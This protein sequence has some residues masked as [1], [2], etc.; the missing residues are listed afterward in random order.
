MFSNK[1]T[2]WDKIVT[3]HRMLT[4]TA[5]QDGKTR[6]YTQWV[7]M[8]TVTSLRMIKTQSWTGWVVFVMYFKKNFLSQHTHWGKMVTINTNSQN[9]NTHTVEQNGNKSQHRQQDKTVTSHIRL[10]CTMGQDGNKSHRMLITHTYTHQDRM[11]T[12]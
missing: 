2:L 9:V 3:S 11:V 7:K 4:H 10:T 1:S 6:Q 12:T 5:G 8:V